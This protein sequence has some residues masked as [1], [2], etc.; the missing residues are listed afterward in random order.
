ML[1]NLDNIIKIVY[2]HVGSE[3]DDEE[4]QVTDIK[5]GAIGKAR[6]KFDAQKVRA[7][8]QQIRKT[9]N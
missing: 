7:S 3:K 1:I 5:R 9:K 8:N 4:T 2:L 6:S